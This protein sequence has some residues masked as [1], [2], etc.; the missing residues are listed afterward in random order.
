MSPYQERL[1]GTVQ[2]V[3]PLLQGQFRHQKLLVASVVISVCWD[4]ATR[5]EGAGIGL[6][7]DERERESPCRS[8]TRRSVCK[9][10][11]GELCMTWQRVMELTGG[12]R[13][14]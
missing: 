13:C 9:K 3:A 12:N 5:E 11:A 4:E 1:L 8:G 6:L 14:V 2:P 7:V 10:G